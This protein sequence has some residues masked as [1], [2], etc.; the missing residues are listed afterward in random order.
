MSGCIP[1]WPGVPGSV[2]KVE[3]SGS[4]DNRLYFCLF[5]L[6]VA[7]AAHP[8]KSGWA[9]SGPLFPKSLL[10]SFPTFAHNIHSCPA[11]GVGIEPCAILDP[12]AGRGSTVPLLSSGRIKTRSHSPSI[13]KQCPH[14]VLSSQVLN[15]SKWYPASPQKEK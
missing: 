10:V 14:Q 3:R 4:S 7:G 8:Q 13:P 2:R 9:H 5:N 12:L 15:T 6:H 11:R 1:A